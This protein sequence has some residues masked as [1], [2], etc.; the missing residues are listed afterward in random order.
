[1]GPRL[2]AQT[3][4]EQLVTVGRVLVAATSIAA[5]VLDPREPARLGETAYIIQ[6]AYLA[7]ASGLLWI[8]RNAPA[9][10][11]WWPVVT[12]A[13]DLVCFASLLLPTEGASSQFYIYFLFALI[14][15]AMR[16]HWRGALLTGVGL[17]VVYMLTG[18]WIAL[19]MDGA[20]LRLIVNR[21]L[22]L[23]LMM[24]MIVS[25]DVYY[26]RQVRQFERLAAWPRGIHDE[27][28]QLA[29]ELLQASARV[30][31]ARRL[32]LVW[33]D[34]EEP[35]VEVGVWNEGRLAWR[36][37]P[38]GTFG[39]LV[40][41]PLAGRA[42]YCADAAAA[43]PQVLCLVEDGLEEWAGV[44]LD[45]ALRTRFEARH[46]LSWPIREEN[47][48]GRLFCL[49]TADMAPDDL[50][51]GAV[52][53]RLVG[54]RLAHGEMVHMLASQSTAGERMRLARDLH[55]GILQSLTAA[56]L[57][58]DAARK[59]LGSDPQAAAERLADIQRILG[60][61]HTDVRT[62][63][64]QLNPAYSGARGELDLAGRLR[65]LAYSI[66]QQWRLDVNLAFEP[67]SIRL[68]DALALEV[69][70]IVHEALVNA[71]RHAGA[72]VLTAA[73]LHA[74]DR[75]SIVVA[76]NGRG[77]GFRGRRGLEALLNTRD[78]PRTLCQRVM[79]I[80]GD[81]AIESTDTGSRVEIELPIAAASH[82]PHRAR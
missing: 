62:F 70:W 45:R 33:E 68:P 60:T 76:D 25:L 46:V 24:A 58:L 10:R 4:T 52:V 61:Q 50:V 57:Q 17:L 44:P 3:R 12:H 2:I 1:V 78:C 14:A 80:S 74:G 22:L 40:A 77:F 49:D 21:S 5:T 43:A 79:A 7:Y 51:L 28:A 35:W 59:L 37:E 36:Q 69:H 55:D 23:L 8:L 41:A 47:V 30:L 20:D 27:R 38:P 72:T 73:L 6:S 9:P 32:L 31:R 56:T 16:W 15:A 29:A 66:E 67:E 48:S 39:E 18:A 63:I 13:A 82:D 34:T 42:F 71:A 81:L 75:L 26:E 54:G 65:S 64:T 53:A 11:A 19:A